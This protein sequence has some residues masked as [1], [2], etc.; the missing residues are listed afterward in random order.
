MGISKKAVV[1]LVPSLLFGIGAPAWSG[2]SE[3]A[4]PID[5]QVMPANPSNNTLLNMIS[6]ILTA[7]DTSP[8]QAKDQCK[9]SQL[10]SQHDVVGDPEACFEGHYT[11]GMGST[12]AAAVS[13]P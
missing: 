4:G 8:R 5:A 1:V 11:L 13:V 6:S 7:T 2:T 3:Q 12:T 10:Y 9:A